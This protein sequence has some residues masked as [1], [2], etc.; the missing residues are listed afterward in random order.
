MDD[1]SNFVAEVW[2][3]FAVAAVFTGLRMYSRLRSVGWRD[4]AVD[5]YLA[6]AAIVSIRAQLRS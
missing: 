1:P 4:I 6:L 5:D 2:T 3:L